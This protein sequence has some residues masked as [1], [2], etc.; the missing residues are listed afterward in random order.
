MAQQGKGV[1]EYG[2]NLR[3]AT[4]D[5][6]LLRWKVAQERCNVGTL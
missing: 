1:K 6:T 3:V 2:L 4:G 5:S